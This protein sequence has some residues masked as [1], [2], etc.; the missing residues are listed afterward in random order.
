MMTKNLNK[1]I[2]KVNPKVHHTG[3]WGEEYAEKAEK[4]VRNAFELVQLHMATLKHLTVDVIT[5]AFYQGGHD[6]IQ[7]VESA[8]LKQCASNLE[9]YEG[10]N[11]AL[12]E[13][14]QFTNLRSLCI[15]EPYRWHQIN[16]QNNPWRLLESLTR[17]ERLEVGQQMRRFSTS[18]LINLRILDVCSFTDDEFGLPD[19][20]KLLKHSPKLEHIILS[21]KQADMMASNLQPIL[22]KL[23]KSPRAKDLLLNADVR[24]WHGN[25]ER[26]QNTLVCSSSPERS[27]ALLNCGDLTRS[28]LH[29][30]AQA[31]PIIR[32][33]KKKQVLVLRLL[34]HVKLHGK[35]GKLLQLPYLDQIMHFAAERGM[36]KFLKALFEMGASPNLR[37][38]S[39]NETLLHTACKGEQFILGLY[40]N[41]ASPMPLNFAALTLK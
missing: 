15:S 40:C 31:S 17:L 3:W 2:I 27:E 5:P 30:S 28:I 35:T 8:M 6:Y 22:N 32:C 25:T 14:S 1:I 20:D 4:E 39:D 16:A 33:I 7:K 18:K 21:G 23:V 26:Y 10:S 38:S 41:C 11:V 29:K 19:V 36:M 9:S 24:L 34:E 13:A 37:V 12:W